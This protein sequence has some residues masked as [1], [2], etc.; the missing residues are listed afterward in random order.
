MV[1]MR[2]SIFIALAALRVH[3][4]VSLYYLLIFILFVVV[5]VIVGEHATA[6]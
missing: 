3:V 5:V 2:I 6:Y 4:R 1:V